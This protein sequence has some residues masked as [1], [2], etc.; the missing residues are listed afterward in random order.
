[1]ALRIGIDMDGTLA[2]LS[3]A[4]RE[5]E[6]TLFIDRDPQVSRGADD[7]EIEEGEQREASKG[8]GAL[9]AARR[10][11]RDRDLVWQ[12][13]RRTEDFWLAL[14]PLEPGIVRR[15]SDVSTVHGWEVFFITQRP[16]TAGQTVQRQTQ[17]WLVR[18]GF[19]M[20]AVLTLVGG[21]G[22]AAAAL[23]LDV[24]LDDYPKNCVDVVSESTCR[25][26]LILRK[27]SASSEDAA[28]R[29]GIG[30]TRSI[31]DAL[32]FLE[33]PGSVTKPNIVERVLGKFVHG[34]GK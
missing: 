20:P 10:E 13:I 17:Q 9:K 5:V 24:L 1:M 3:S 25:P 15:L 30:V 22:K 21:R 31:A 16:A 23:E 29:L 11:A 18:E 19:E 14:H 6:R 4:Y 33:T 7:E 27:P 2:D 28:K 34:F 8:K 12:A 26:I 32:T